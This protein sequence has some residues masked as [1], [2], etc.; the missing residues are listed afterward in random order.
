MTTYDVI[1]LGSPLMD[2]TIQV[3][4]K[5][6]EELNLK[7]GGMTL[8]DE[9]MYSNIISKISDKK[10]L[11]STGGSASNTIKGVSVLGGKSAFMG[12]IGN[13]T[14]GT[15]YNNL[16]S[17]SNVASFLSK[18]ESHTGLSIIC[19]TPDYERTMITYLGAATEFSEN[20]IN[21]KAI[22]ESKILH[23]EGFFIELEKN[24]NSVLTAMKIAK[25]NNVKISMDLSDS[26]L[27]QRKNGLLKQIMTDYVDI[28]FVNEHEALAFT[29]QKEK[30]ALHA[31]SNYC[32]IS[33]V[34]L[35]SKGSLIKYVDKINNKYAVHDIP[36]HKVEVV[37][38]NGAGDAYAAGILYS[39]A[40]NI[41]LDK[42]GKLASY[43]SG[44]VVGIDAATIDTISKDDIRKVLE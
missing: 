14:Y 44:K 15:H 33:I 11:E 27:I 19:I 12:M 10:T 9:K 39:I 37:N 40:N 34:K 22:M 1:G 43:I 18:C 32:D 31:L 7:K 24:A 42:A 26:G 5:F 13:D 20:D 38:T 25:E 30:E 29:G 23:V 2:I 4:D 36:I 6:L 8:I 17:D 35:G 41:P 28:V 21:K 16:L 3:D